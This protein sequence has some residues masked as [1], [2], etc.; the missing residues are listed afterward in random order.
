MAL[1][2]AAISGSERV[3]L[4]GARALGRTNPHTVVEVMLKLRRIH[5]LPELTT[6]ANPPMSRE[7]MAA[8]HGASAED[9]RKVVGV[10]EE[11]GLKAV[12]SDA[13]TRSVKLAGPV[14]RLEEAFGV[15]LFN[16]AHASGAYRGRVGKVYVPTEVEGIVEGVFGLDNRRAVQPRRQPV[17]YAAMPHNAAKPDIPASWY[18]PSELATHYRFPAGDGAGQTV[19]ILEFGG[20]YFESDLQDFCKLCD[21]A[22]LPTV[23]TVSVD[24]T[25][26]SAR[27]GAEGEVMLDVEVVAG[28]CPKASLVVYFAEFSIRGWIAA[29]DAAVHDQK[30]DPGVVSVSWGYAETKDIWTKQGMTQVNEALLEA[31]HLGVTVCVASGDDGS[32]G[33]IGNGHAYVNFP[34]SSPYALSVGGTTIPAKGSAQPDIVWKEGD[35]LRSDNGGS[36]GGGESTVWPRPTWQSAINIASVNPHAIAGR[37][38]PDLS[39][40]ADWDA[41]PYLLAVDGSIEANGGTSAATPLVGALLTLINADR[42]AAGKSRVGFVTPQLYQPASGEPAGSAPVG[43]LACTD[44][45]DGD[46]ITAHVGGYAA[47]PGF[48]AA[49]G[50]GTPI[51]T[52]LAQLLA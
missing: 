21:I 43:S 16:Y 15:K 45:V 10:F 23:R 1:D 24:G 20:R 11:L 49:S 18:R 40:N 42:V 22:P 44:V 36:T 17:R 6:K 27:D 9:I 37:I 47:A 38:V 4:P 7:Q 33:A 34:T 2:L 30:N 3:A 12:G 31:A 35:G 32:S 5:P 48:D 8:E 26:T 50:W 28:V 19:G 39:A 29:I 41:S 51:G 46:N 14:A 25:S 52:R 13:A